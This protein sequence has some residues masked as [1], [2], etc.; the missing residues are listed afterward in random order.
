MKYE[1]SCGTIIIDNDKVLILKHNKGH[2]DFPKGHME[3]DETEYDTALRET[4]EE[5]NLDVV[6]DASKRY[7]VTYSP[8]EGVIK[9]VVYFKATPIT[10]DIEP[11]IKEIKEVKWFSFTD[12]LDILTHD[13]SKKILKKIIEEVKDVKI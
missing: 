13:D 12:A 10:K 4:K 6:I 9:D 7:V 3:D 5:T 11:Q 1:K 8:K 2:W